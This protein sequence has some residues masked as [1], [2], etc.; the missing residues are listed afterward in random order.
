MDIQIENFKIKDSEGIDLFDLY[1][2]KVAQSGKSQGESNDVAFGY[3]ISFPRCI[4]IIIQEKMK[5]ENALV[6][7]DQYIEAYEKISTRILDEVRK[8]FVKK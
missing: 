6:N 3:G 2:V 4:Q 7:L 5:V 1:E 8:I